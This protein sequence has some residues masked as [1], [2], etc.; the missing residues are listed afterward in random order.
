MTHDLNDYDLARYEWQISVPGFGLEGQ[1]ILKNSSVMISRVGGLGSLVALELAA[2]GIGKLVLAHA[3]NA[4]ISDLNRQILLNADGVDSPRLPAIEYRL[5][6]FRPDLEIESFDENL[7]EENA[8]RIV[9]K[10]DLVVDC[11]PLFSE[12]FAMNG[13][14]VRQNKPLVECAMYEL[15]WQLMSILPR[16]TAC[17]SCLHPKTPEAW[18]RQFPVFGAVSGTVGCMGAMEAIKILTKLGTPLYGE[19]LRCDMREMKFQKL[20]LR[21]IMDCFVCGSIKN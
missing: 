19:L 2:A 11:A 7:N 14:C 6:A 5:R 9:G 21:R 12:R 17:L 18:K 20:K 15:E 8:D 10:A 1:R 16:Q 13:A 3:G 4:K